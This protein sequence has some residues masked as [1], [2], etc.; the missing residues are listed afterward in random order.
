MLVVHINFDQKFKQTDIIFLFT[1][2]Q[3]SNWSKMH[4]NRTKIIFTFHNISKQKILVL[5]I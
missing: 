5:K 1:S 4:N 2:I 3:E